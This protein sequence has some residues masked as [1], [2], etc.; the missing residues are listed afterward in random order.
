MDL[1]GPRISCSTSAC[2]TPARE[3]NAVS[4]SARRTSADRLGDGTVGAAGRRA[5][6]CSSVGVGSDG[7]VSRLRGLTGTSSLGSGGR[8]DSSAS[9]IIPVRVRRMLIDSPLVV[10]FG[11]WLSV[12]TCE[13]RAH[14]RVGLQV[15]HTVVIHHAKT[16]AAEGVGECERHLRFGLHDPSAHLLL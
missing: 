1:G 10:Q 12:L 11:A 15:L 6:R 16:T 8:A 4:T 14:P 3:D 13:R 7:G 5:G 2:R 9:F